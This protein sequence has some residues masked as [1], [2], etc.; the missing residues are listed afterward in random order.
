MKCR[1]EI[2]FLNT[3]EDTSK[4]KLKFS[5]M[6]LITNTKFCKSYSLGETI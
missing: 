4:S 2:N 3:T 1:N 5:K 6:K